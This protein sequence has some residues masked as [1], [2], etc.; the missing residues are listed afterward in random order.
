[1]RGILLSLPCITSNFY[2]Y[3]KVEMKLEMHGSRERRILR[4]VLVT[5]YNLRLV[6]A[7]LPIL[8]VGY[9]ER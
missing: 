9:I 6:S 1:M 4:Q 5:A 7:G 8:V 2:F 3:L